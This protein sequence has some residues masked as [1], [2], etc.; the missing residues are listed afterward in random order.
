MPLLLPHLLHSVWWP[1]VGGKTLMKT[2]ITT[3]YKKLLPS[4]LS[5]SL[6]KSF[7]SMLKVVTP[8]ISFCRMC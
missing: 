3:Y 7:N 1:T 8:R 5:L 4:P 2:L 6:S